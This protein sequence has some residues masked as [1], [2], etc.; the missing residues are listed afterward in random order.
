MTFKAQ[1]AADADIFTN[2]EE[3]GV[4]AVYSRA[5]DPINVLIDKEQEMETGRFVD[6]ITA[7]ASDV[8]GLAPGDTFTIGGEVFYVTAK[9]PIT[10]D[11]VFLMI[12]VDKQ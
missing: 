3:F 9:E 11:E 5:I 12:R 4:S 8:E 1:M 10:I 2:P 7:K 6:Y